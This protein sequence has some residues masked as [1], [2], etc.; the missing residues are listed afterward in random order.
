MPVPLT[1]E[2]TEPAFGMLE[3]IRECAGEQLIA[4][5][6]LETAAGAHAAYY[7]ALAAEAE[8]RLRGSE[9]ERWLAHLESERANLRG[10]L[11]W[12]REQ[13]DGELGLRLA[14]AL[15]RF[16]ELR[17]HLTEGRTWLETMLEVGAAAPTRLRAA[18][19]DTAGWLAFN[20]ADYRRAMALH[21]EA[22]ALR[23]E[24]GDRNGIAASLHALG[25]I[26]D[27]HGEVG[28][29][30]A[31]L[32]EALELRRELRD[33]DGI[34]MSLT[35]L[36]ALAGR[37]GDFERAGVLFEEA[38]AL[39]RELGDRH[40]IAVLL[41]NL[42]VLAYWQGDDERAEILLEEALTIARTAGSTE[43]FHWT[44][45]YLGHVASRRGDGVAAAA[46][47]RETIQLCC[48]SGEAKARVL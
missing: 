25:T 10:A 26:A 31:L 47:Y 7:L 27:R 16:W 22:L 36:G 24:L 43:W 30:V 6:E 3:T 37:Q 21:E 40:W 44:V 33:R 13:G 46:H 19:L 35:N 8:P 23:R 2:E 17:G 32:E 28:P 15:G 9:Q 29:A 12:S 18:A 20:Q 41:S 1:E 4:Q 11:S 5:G 34:A 39:L 42:G 48:D 14:N 45:L 38:L